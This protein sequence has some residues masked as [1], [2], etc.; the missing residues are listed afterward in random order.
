MHMLALHGK[1]YAVVYGCPEG[2]EISGRQTG[3]CCN[4]SACSYYSNHLQC[5]AAGFS[6]QVC[7]CPE[8]AGY[9]E[10]HN[11]L[12]SFN[13]AILLAILPSYSV[14]KTCRYVVV[15]EVPKNSNPLVV[16]GMHVS[17]RI[18]I[19]SRPTLPALSCCWLFAAGMLSL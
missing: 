3:V 8:D 6:L 2:A 7:G 14:I 13:P 17:Q 15:V 11:S 1:Q 9:Q 10:K 16:P 19:C 4:T 18:S 12:L 5:R